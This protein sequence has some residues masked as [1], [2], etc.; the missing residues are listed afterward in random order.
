MPSQPPPPAKLAPLLREPAGRVG[1]DRADR[2][3]GLTD[4]GNGLEER[5]REDFPRVEAVI[6]DFF[7]PAEKLT[8]LSQRL[9]P[10][11][12]ARAEE[13]ARQWCGLL[14]SE[15]GAIL[16][17][18]LSEWDWPRRAGLKEA[19]AEL[20]GDLERHGRVEEWRGGFRLGLA[21]AGPFGRRCLNSLTVPRFHSPLIEP[22]GRV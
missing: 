4:G 17:A 9:H 5:L 21:V 19:A 3:L 7:H 16:A 22:D 13:Q 18:V 8:G 12:E 10:G 2:W 15:G 1:M 20:V 11:E 14:K 6:L